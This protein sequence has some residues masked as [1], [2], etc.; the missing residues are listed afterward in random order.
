[1]HIYSLNEDFEKDDKSGF[2]SFGAKEEKADPS[3]PTV[4]DLDL[5]KIGDTFK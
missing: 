4:E 3:I 2:F 5:S 1:M